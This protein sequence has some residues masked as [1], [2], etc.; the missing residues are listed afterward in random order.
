MY[1]WKKLRIQFQ[2]NVLGN[3]E[4][5]YTNIFNDKDKYMYTTVAWQIENCPEVKKN[6]LIRTHP[7]I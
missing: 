4:K 1:L 2:K 5:L 7:S 3:H 6:I